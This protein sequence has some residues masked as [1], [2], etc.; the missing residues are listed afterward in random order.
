MSIDVTHDS[1]QLTPVHDDTDP[2]H[3]GITGQPPPLQFHPLT[4]KIV[5]VLQADAN[6]HIVE[7]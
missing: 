1:L 2:S 5:S 4:P 3:T 6:K 7:S